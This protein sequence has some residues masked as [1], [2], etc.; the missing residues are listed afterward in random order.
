MNIDALRFPI[1]VFVV[2]ENFTKEDI[3]H[4]KNE[5]ALL[6]ERLKLEIK[7]IS[8]KELNTPYRPDGWTVKQVIHHLADSHMNGLIR[9]KLA[10]TE[11]NPVIKPYLED[12]WA[13]LPDYKED[14]STSIKI[15]EGV[16]ARWSLVFG[17]MSEN[18][19]LKTYFHPEMQKNVQLSTQLANYAWHSN[20]HLAHIRLVTKPTSA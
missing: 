10:L 3:N 6:P 8:E 15:L 19:F 4:W 18:D 16:H 11:P 5:I 1:G 9:T 17:N 13:T 2:P 20:H 7:N 12:V 14:I